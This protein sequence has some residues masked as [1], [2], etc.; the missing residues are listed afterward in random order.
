MSDG[1]QSSIFVCSFV[2]KISIRLDSTN[3][4][5]REKLALE[6]A[7]TRFRNILNSVALN[8][9]IVVS[10]SASI[11]FETHSVNLVSVD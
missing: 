10:D 1:H 9:V 2:L 5:D 6:F 7:L 11:N 8:S 4:S 3:Q